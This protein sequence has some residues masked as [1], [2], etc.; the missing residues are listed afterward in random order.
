[1]V[2]ILYDKGLV[3]ARNELNEYL[4]A[5]HRFLV[6]GVE[7]R[8]MPALTSREGAKNGPNQTSLSRSRRTLQYEHRFRGARYRSMN[9]VTPFSR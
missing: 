9:V 8:G 5:L 6:A 7:C 2:G 4:V 1:M 3:P